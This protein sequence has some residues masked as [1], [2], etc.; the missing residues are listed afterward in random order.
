MKITISIP[1]V[2]IILLLVLLSACKSSDLNFTKKDVQS[3]QKLIGLEIEDQ[4]IGD[5]HRYIGRNKAGYDSMRKYPIDNE[6]FPAL[7]FDPHP[8]GFEFPE[9]KTPNNTW[10][11]PSGTPLPATDEEIAFLNIPELAGLL[12]SKKLTSERLTQIYLDRIEKYDSQL[13][14][15][16]TVTKAL[17][18][19]QARQADNDIQSGNY[20]GLLHGIPYGVKDLM[21]VE[22]YPTTWGAAPYKNQ[23]IDYT[24]TVVKMLEEKG[25]VL[26]AKL[27]SG[28]LARGD[29]WFG[30]KTKNPWDLKQG[31]SGSS[32]GPGS[33]TAAGL[34]AFSLGTETLGSIT[35]PSTR[36]GITGLRPTYGRVSR[37]GTMSLSWSMDKIGPMC[38]SAEDC[39]IVFD[40][41]YGKDELDPTTN[42]VAFHQV[43]KAPSELKVAYL[44]D[45][46]DADSTSSMGKNLI[47]GLA[48]LKELGVNPT[49]ISLPKNYPFNVFDI[50]LRAEAG[51]F[52]DELVFSQ[53]V[54]KM[55]EQNYGSRAN[56]L[57]QSRFIPAVEYLQANRQ[58]RQLM[59]DIHELFKNYDVIIAPSF[60][61]RQLFITNLTGHPVVSIPT[62]FDKRSR[63]TSMTFIGNLY[64]EGSILALAKA[65][66]AETEFDEKHPPLFSKSNQ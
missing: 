59:D 41:I 62:G 29:V 35:S 18:L 45:D 55:V 23:M 22:G 52:F 10:D 56:S 50:I 31:A 65:Y 5:M 12:R 32:A 13:F 11:I 48:V 14:S 40:A 26:I 6:T 2:L 7:T 64:D 25:A 39:E 1:S 37:N 66:Q 51:A 17:A 58:R 49:A 33:A 63:P 21:A 47:K 43:K 15:V 46:I 61:G 42:D 8:A 19:K 30:G 34:V 16:I 36:N 57:R 44:K 27:V 53:E 38:R 3:S 28:S 54:D 4:Y 60:R 9:V 24:A 20:K